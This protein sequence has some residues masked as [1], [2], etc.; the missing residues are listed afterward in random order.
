[1]LVSA[2]TV[3]GMVV[4]GG[5]TGAFDGVAELPSRVFAPAYDAVT[6][7]NLHDL[8]LALTS[9]GLDAGSY[10]GLTVTALAGWGWTPNDRT[11]VTIWVEKDCFRVVAQDVRV[12][13]SQFEFSS[14]PGGVSSGV[15][16]R[17]ATQ[18]A[19]PPAMATA[20]VI[21]ATGL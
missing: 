10:D 2:A 15:V 18:P 4:V 11:A 5:G 7:A 12:G 1:M 3:L 17:S 19:S 13:A 21:P 14:R 20:T 16:R 6:V 8:A 9:Y